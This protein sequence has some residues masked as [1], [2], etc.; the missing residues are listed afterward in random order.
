MP[1][2]IPKKLISNS[3]WERQKSHTKAI[4]RVKIVVQF[5]LENSIETN[6]KLRLLKIKIY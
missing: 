5:C 4:Q 1:E 6:N 2:P 3:N